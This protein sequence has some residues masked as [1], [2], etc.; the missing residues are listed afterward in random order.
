MTYQSI[1]QIKQANAAAGYHFFDADT[2]RFFRSRVSDRLYGGK[3]FV[4]SECGPSEVRAY[5]VRR[6]EDNGSI[7]TVEP[8]NRLTRSAA[9]ALAARLAKAERRVAA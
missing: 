4:T 1:D 2:L 9:H 8:F 6:A 3:W 7:Q 5:T